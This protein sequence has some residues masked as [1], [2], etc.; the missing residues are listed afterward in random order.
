MPG[1]AVWLRPLPARGGEGGVG[2]YVAPG[3]IRGL[4][5]ARL[6]LMV[7]K[8]DWLLGSGVSQDHHNNKDDQGASKGR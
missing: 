3:F 4:R 1:G 2:L 6:K 8:L 5:G 7:D